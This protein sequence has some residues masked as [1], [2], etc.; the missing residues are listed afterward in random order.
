MNKKNSLITSGI[1]LILAL[2]FLLVPPKFLGIVYFRIV[3]LGFIIM[4]IFKL[5]FT[6][7][8]DE[9]RELAFNIVEGSLAIILGVIYFYFYE[10]LTIDIICFLG[11]LII[12]ILRL[13]YA[14]HLVN[15]IS[16]DLL[17]YI[18]IVSFLGGYTK[19]SKSFFIFCGIIWLLLLVIIWIAYFRLR[20]ERSGKED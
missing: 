2:I 14:E 11:M 4:G 3:A 16:F 8:S 7:L 6:S 18:G 9:K 13:I 5:A 17:K 19:V 1:C 20:R 15:Q 12:P 10:Y